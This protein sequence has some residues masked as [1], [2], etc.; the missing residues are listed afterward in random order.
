MFMQEGVEWEHKSQVPGKMHACGHDA[1]VAMLLCAAKMLQEFKD[2]LKVFYIS[3]LL[4]LVNS[5]LS[6]I[7]VIS[8]V[9]F[10]KLKQF[11]YLDVLLCS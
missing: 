11:K 10:L 1:H 7:Y 4:N 9:W 2:E 8:S 6:F 5:S 3:P